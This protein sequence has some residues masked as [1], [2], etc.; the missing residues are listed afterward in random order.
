MRY[1]GCVYVKKKEWAKKLTRDFVFKRNAS[2]ASSF[3]CG[4]EVG[5]R[6]SKPLARNQL[7]RF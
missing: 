7:Q 2:L 4:R 1:Q 6:W 3:D 5:H